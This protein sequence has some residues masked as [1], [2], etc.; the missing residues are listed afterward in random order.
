MEQVSYPLLAEQC[1]FETLENGM[2]IIVVPRS[3]YAK[4]TVL[5]AV[6]FGDQDTHIA[7]HDAVRQVPAGMAHYLGQYISSLPTEQSSVAQEVCR[8]SVYTTRDLTYFSF[9]CVD[10]WET[11]LQSLLLQMTE[12]CFSQAQLTHTSQL[13]KQEQKNITSAQKCDQALLCGLFGGEPVYQ[14]MDH[15]LFTQEQV[16]QAHQAF[17]QPSR[18]VLCVM[19][20]VSPKR[21]IATVRMLLS[22]RKQYSERQASLD[23]EAHIVAPLSEEYIASAEPCYAI[24]FRSPPIE[25]GT[26]Y[27][28]AQLVGKIAS[29]ILWREA[30]SLLLQLQQE[31]FPQGVHGTY[32]VYAPNNALIL[33]G[34][35]GNPQ[36]IRAAILETGQKLCQTGIPQSTFHCAVRAVYGTEIQNLDQPNLTAANLARSAFADCRYFDFAACCQS[37]TREEVSAFLSCTLTEEQCAISMIHSV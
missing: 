37:V 6:E 5:C 29:Q 9:S 13:L 16:K 22:Q 24:G 34:K 26:A 31:A 35:Q 18:M 25:K 33:S 28:R 3:G 32:R 12:P 8:P 20:A 30:T 15:S 21:V 10:R 7:S 4:T 27:L 17:Y 14:A 1:Y 36:E 11:R 2:R 19:G 23:A